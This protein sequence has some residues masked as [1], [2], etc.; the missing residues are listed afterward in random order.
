[1][2]GWLAILA[3]GFFLGMRHATDADHVLAVTT[4]VARHRA[5]RDAAM[6]GVFWGVGHTLTILTVGSGIVLF[7]WV[8]PPRVGLSM[9]LAVGA[10]L[11][12]LGA[13]T[14]R[15][16]LENVDETIA[17]ARAAGGHVHSH[18]H[19][20]GEY[21]HTHAHGHEPEAH[22]HAPDRT[23]VARL[24]RRFGRFGLYSAIRPIVIGMVHGL[25]GSAAVALLVLTTI[26][27]PRW[28]VLYLGLFGSGTIIGM[29]LITMAI[30]VPFAT[31]AGRFS[32]WNRRLRLASGALS[33]GFG[34]FVAWRVGF[35][36]GLF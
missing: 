12:L 36:E 20:H 9:E 25:A 7:G 1:M 24:D 29:M 8:I 30:A 19:A 35:V 21:I 16:V 3:F 18:A 14:L 31:T 11:V 32:Q 4:I 23:P 22:P 13:I 2:T 17:S 10:M 33:L 6:V 34:L 26:R 27:E 5:V 15:S 28:S